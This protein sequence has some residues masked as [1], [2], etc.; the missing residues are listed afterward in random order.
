MLMQDK[1]GNVLDVTDDGKRAR[2]L[3]DGW[4]DVGVPD[5]AEPSEPSEPDGEPA[6]KRRGRPPKV[7]E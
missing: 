6:Q 2:M 4:A 7:R 5:A 3:A 1:A